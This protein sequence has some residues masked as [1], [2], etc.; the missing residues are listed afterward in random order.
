MILLQEGNFVIQLSRAEEAYDESPSTAIWAL[1]NA[2]KSLD[3]IYSNRMI[4]ERDYDGYRYIIYSRILYFEKT[5]GRDT[6]KTVRTINEIR[7]NLGDA[8]EKTESE[9][10]EAI[11]GSLKNRYS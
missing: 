9:I 2:L 6:A 7:R 11:S 4:T 8:D 1:E 10:L 3:D 5:D